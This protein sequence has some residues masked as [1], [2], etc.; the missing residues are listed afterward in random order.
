MNA[1][2]VFGTIHHWQPSQS[3][4]LLQPPYSLEQIS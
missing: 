2:D 3:V 4:D 1:E